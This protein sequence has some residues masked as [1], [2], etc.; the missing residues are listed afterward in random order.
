MQIILFLIIAVIL[1]PGTAFSGA[2][3]GVA[4][5]S[6]KTE[7]LKPYKTGKYK[8]VCG[9]GIPNESI[10]ID[11]KG[12]K[13]SVISLHGKKLKK[14]GGEYKLDQK[15][16]RY[17]PHVIAV[18]LDS[19]LKIH[20]SDPINHNI[21]TYSFENDPINIMFL[22]GQ[23]AYSQE[24]EEAEVIKVECDL[25]DWMRAW[26]VVT[27]NAYSAV[28]G[29]DGS[30]EI[31]DVPPGKYELT[32]WHETLGSLTKNITVGNDGLNVNFDFL[33]VSLEEENR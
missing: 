31:P 25:H 5:F 23:D 20:T 21:H 29:A 10:L 11:N 3:Q 2:I 32:A 4:I 27:P 28:S 9:S 30:F 17:E 15:K 12:V 18:P 8:K 6:G 1:M 7:Q 13:N 26:V 14:R 24:M 16:C 22:P 33:E 19:E